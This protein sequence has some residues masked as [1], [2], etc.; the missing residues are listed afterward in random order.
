MLGA[1]L[2]QQLLSFLTK[3]IPLFLTKGLDRRTVAQK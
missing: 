3:R 2:L 1:F